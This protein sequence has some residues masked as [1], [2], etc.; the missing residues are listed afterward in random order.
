[1]DFKKK[2]QELERRCIQ[3]E[4]P[5]CTAA[6]PLH[7]DA[8]KFVGYIAQGR[9][10]DAWQVLEKTMPFPSILARIC[11]APCQLQCKRREAGDSIR[12]G[13]LEFACAS[14]MA[15]SHQIH[16]PF[17]KGKHVAVMGSGLSSLTA[18]L[19]LAR[20]GYSVSIFDTQERF[21]GSLRDQFSANLTD[22]IIDAELAV[23]W[24]LN[25]QAIVEK[26]L[27]SLTFLERCLH[28]FDAVYFGLEATSAEH[29]LLELDEGHPIR[30][31]SKVQTTEREGL[32]AGGRTAS[33]VRQ[34]A[35]GRWAAVSIA[36]FF[37]G[38]S[39]TAG[40]ENEGPHAT[41]LF[42]NLK[43]IPFQPKVPMSDTS[44][45]LP[46]ESVSEAQRCLQC[47]CL[48]CVKVCAYLER[49]GAYPKKYARDIHTNEVMF[50]GNH[51]ANK[52]INSCSLCGLCEEVC[53]ENFAMQELCLG[54]R[55]SMVHRGKMPPTPH[56]FPMRDMLFS[57]SEKCAL[58]R[59]QPGTTSSRY[60][61]FPGCQLAAS[62]PQH[63]KNAYALLTDKLS[64]GV[65][66]ILGCCGAPAEWSGRVEAMRETVESFRM[67][68]ESMG[69]PQLIL[70]CS[71][72]H[73]VFRSHLT[74]ASVVSLW[75]VL[76]EL[77]VPEAQRE[78]QSAPLA[79]HDACT[80]R[81]EE[82]IHTSVRN[83]LKRCGLSL[84]ELP[85]SRELTQCCG[86]GGLMF[87]ANPDLASETVRRRIEQSQVD[88]VVYCAMC[89]DRFAS[90]GKRTIHLLDVIFGET[91]DKAATRSG[92]KYSQRH[93][94]RIHLK[95]DLSREL[96]GE[97]V[98]EKK[99]LEAYRL[100]ISPR[101]QELMEI[102]LILEDDVR[103]VIHH[104]ESTGAKMQNRRSC[105][106]VAHYRPT[107]VTYWVE[108]SRDGEEYVVHNTYSH[109][110]EVSEEAQ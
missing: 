47:G 34:M 39:L 110:M 29:W 70:A 85:L 79:V 71:S 49:F 81:H 60:V 16:A 64:G 8:R 97:T 102:R 24:Q 73:N 13:D 57:N 40:R 63:V 33:P 104:A 50:K 55:Q 21:G 92:P 37:E 2:L 12:I 44:G 38:V 84:Q 88:Y 108:Y 23:L 75:E 48:E 106:T 17:A 46:T 53:P 65:G 80:T 99:G 67:Q 109:R 35:E 15:P 58:A 94:N 28:S 18:A 31:I 61:F 7:V 74:N 6:C 98:A 89:R 30:V 95:N 69:C 83:I 87:F 77:G 11:D 66:L 22:E 90:Q 25:V 36:R 59:H 42:V 26:D 82:R 3:D 86:Y 32:F 51:K 41:R 9:W 100:R 5:G 52:L 107:E 72:C 103:S 105:H 20:K 96:W 43:D 93:E 14:A 56:D 76:D 62:A 4:P 68:W 19:D 91:L 27:Y 101:V 78:V 45:Y 1:M 54:A 10:A